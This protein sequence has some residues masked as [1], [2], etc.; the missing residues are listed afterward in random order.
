MNSSKVWQKTALEWKLKC[1][2]QKEGTNRESGSGSWI[3]LAGVELDTDSCSSLL[4]KRKQAEG[5][6]GLGPF[7]CSIQPNFITLL[8]LMFPGGLPSGKTPQP[9][10]THWSGHHQYKRNQAEMVRFDLSFPAHTHPAWLLDKKTKHTT[11]PP[12]NKQTS[13]WLAYNPL[14]VWPAM[15]GIL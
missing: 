12:T 5:V 14:P 8:F 15:K 13:W 3:L 4:S 10:L 11:N 9:C 2:P 7:I 6:Q 1:T